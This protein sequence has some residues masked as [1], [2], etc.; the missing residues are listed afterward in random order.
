MAMAAQNSCLWLH[1]F[2]FRFP[3]FFFLENFLVAKE[4]FTKTLFSSKKNYKILQLFR[5]IKSYSTCIKY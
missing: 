2:R 1:C 3:F 4:L 5:H